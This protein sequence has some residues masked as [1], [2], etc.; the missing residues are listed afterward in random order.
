MSS[1]PF[2]L[3]PLFSPSCIHAFTHS[4]FWYPPTHWLLIFSRLLTN[5]LHFLIFPSPSV[6]LLSLLQPL[7]QP[8]FILIS[9]YA[10]STQVLEAA[11]YLPSSYCLPFPFLL[12]PSLHSFLQSLQYQHF[13]MISTHLLSSHVLKGADYLL[14]FPCLPLPLSPLPPTI[15]F[16]HTSSWYPP[17]HRLLKD[18]NNLSSPPPSTIL[19]VS[20]WVLLLLPSTYC[21]SSS[22]LRD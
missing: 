2:Y 6:S 21:L 18:G 5:F 15:I 7:L 1:S 13:I 12:L 3:S 20:I 10:L 17:T 14:S 9:T 4:S 22:V 19:H 11:D 16:T 8:H